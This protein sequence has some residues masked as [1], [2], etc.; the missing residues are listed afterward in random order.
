MEQPSSCSHINYIWINPATQILCRL[1]EKKWR[2]SVKCRPSGIILILLAPKPSS[3]RFKWRE[4]RS[5][6]V[7]EDR[8]WRLSVSFS[9]SRD[10][11]PA[12]RTDGRTDLTWVLSELWTQS[13]HYWLVWTEL[14]P[15]AGSLQDLVALHHRG[16]QVLVKLHDKKKKHTTVTGESRRWLVLTGAPNCH[17]IYTAVPDWLRRRWRLVRMDN[18]SSLDSFFII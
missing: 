11:T 8:W 16:P 1:M 12:G 15:P 10:L 3:Q 6:K 17:S 2:K 7:T 4:F 9:K 18:W 5:P 13:A 14:L